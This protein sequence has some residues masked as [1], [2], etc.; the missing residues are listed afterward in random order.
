[1]AAYLAKKG[2]VGVSIAYV[3]SKTAAGKAAQVTA[4]RSKAVIIQA[5]ILS[6]N[7]GEGHP[8]RPFQPYD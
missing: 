2:A 7:S 5:D 6:N 4:L 3:G 8:E 1:V